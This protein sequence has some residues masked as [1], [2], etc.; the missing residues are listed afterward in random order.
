MAHALKR[1]R[2]SRK[3]LAISVAVGTVVVAA[4]V[5]STVLTAQSSDPLPGGTTLEQIDGGPNYFAQINPKSSWLDQHM[6]LGGW[7]EDPTTATDVQYDVAMGNNIYWNLAGKPAGTTACTGSDCRVNYN[8]IR[9]AGMHVVAPDITAESGSE[10][11]AY[12]GSDEADLDYG[13]G[14]NG[15]NSKSQSQ[16]MSACIPSGSACGFTVAK[17]FYTTKPPEYGDVAQPVANLPVYQNNGLAALFWETE[18]QAAQFF[19]YSDILSADTYWMADSQLASA[20]QGACAITP[21]SA[22][23]GYGKGPGLT[24]AQRALPANYAW[25]VTHIAQIEAKYGQSKPIVADIETS[26]IFSGCSTPAASRAA[27]WQAIIAGARGIMWFQQAFTGPCQATGTFYEGSDPSSGEYNCQQT[28]G[29]T[30]HDVVQNITAVNH[31]ITSLNSVLLA[32]FAENYVSV[33]KADVSAMAKYS[34]GTFYVFAASGKPATPPPPNQSVTFKLAGNYTGKV[35]V[36]DEGRT[37]QAV[38]GVFT[39]KFAN[40]DSVHIYRIG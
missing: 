17:H 12:A 18:A 2:R 35:T 40:E 7:L 3:R 10:T 23:C 30:L 5:V 14:S 34:N 32:P 11:V 20:T 22:A 31:E 36:V 9:A 39:D 28:P 1:P 13:A 27:A 29:V 15:W 6:L 16:T 38:N 21:N 24:A 8:V 19:S 4:I 37:L 33:G 25:N 26:C